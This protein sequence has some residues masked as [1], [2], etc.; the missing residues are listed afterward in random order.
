MKPRVLLLLCLSLLA[1]TN[2]FAEAVEIN[3]IYYNLEFD[4]KTAEVTSNPNKYTGTVVVPATV[5]YEGAD[6]SVTSIGDKAFYNCSDLTSLTIANTVSFIGSDAFDGCDN[7][8]FRE[9]SNALY[10][11]SSTNSYA[12]LIKAKT[13]SITY[14]TIHSSCKVISSSAFYNCSKLVTMEIPSNVVSIGNDAFS[15]CYG[16]RILTIHDGV[17]KIGS[18]AFQS[19]YALTSVTLPNSVTSVSNS[20]FD[21]CTALASV[22]IPNSVTEIGERAFDGCSKLTSVN[23]PDGVTSIGERAFRNCTSLT[24]ITIPESVTN[25]GKLAFTQCYSLESV[26][27]PENITSIAN[28]VFNNCRNLASIIIPDNVTSIGDGAFLNCQSLTSII[29]PHKVATIGQGTFSGCTGLATVTVGRSVTKIGREAF[30]ECTGLIDFYCYAK[31]VPNTAYD[32]FKNASIKNATLHTP[33]ESVNLYKADYLWSGFGTIVPIEGEEPDVKVCAK[34][35]ISYA[36]GKL[37]FYCETEGAI[38]QSTIT[39]TDINSFSGN[40]VEL[41]VT[42]FISVYATKEGYVNSEVATAILCW[43]DM[44][45]QTEGVEDAVAEVKALPVLIQTQGGAI[46]VQGAAEGTNVFVYGV[47]GMLQG[48]AI[49]DEGIAILNTSLQPGSVAIVKIGEKAVKVLLK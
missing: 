18:G 26:N 44:E 47:N 49:A 10:L 14:A 42:Y 45:P 35:T 27:I 30:E 36:N 2:S 40:E 5:A 38:C 37:T 20:I 39:D 48:S 21:N 9:N 17:T 16:L 6:Y 28:S 22:T 8:S 34:P 13:T 15:D 41:S 12:F 3:G 19:C 24:A 11:G 43:I 33:V 29:V 31:Q 46:T 23:I 25:I 7:L 4:T 32:T 1:S